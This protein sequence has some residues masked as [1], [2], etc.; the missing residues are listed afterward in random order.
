[1]TA[2]L[3]VVFALWF[4]LTLLCQFIKPTVSGRLLR[5]DYPGLIPMY[6]VFDRRVQDL[7]LYYRSHPEGEWKPF[8]E[9]REARLR[10]IIWNPEGYRHK[11][12]WSHLRSLSDFHHAGV[13]IAPYNLSN[14][15]L[16]N[17]LLEETEC[18]EFC[19]FAVS[20]GGTIIYAS[21]GG[22]AR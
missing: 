11:I 8:L 16:E 10:Q 7:T 14:Q 4:G 5:W 6:R 19:Q 9:Q 2:F 21:P 15:G 18:R 17:I 12:L 20:E 13:P 1:M 22:F 3:T